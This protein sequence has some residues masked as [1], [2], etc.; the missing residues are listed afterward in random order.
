V[1]VDSA[2]ATDAESA[3]EEKKV[4]PEVEKI[5]EEIVKVGLKQ[6]LTNKFSETA[7]KFNSKIEGRF[8]KAH[9]KSAY[10]FNYVS[11][12]WEETFPK[13][14]KRAISKIEA[15]KERARLAKELEE[16]M[17]EMSPEELEEYYE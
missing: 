3:S 1:K 4:D 17:E 16:K 10:Y 14:H 2:K 12:V 9:A 7:A 8:P 13:E 5:T 15:R 6:R 11:E